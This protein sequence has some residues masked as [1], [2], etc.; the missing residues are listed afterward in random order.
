MVDIIGDWWFV[1]VNGGARYYC[2]TE[3]AEGVG[4]AVVEVSQGRHERCGQGIHPPS[5]LAVIVCLGFA[6]G[7]A[8]GTHR[9]TKAERRH[10]TRDVALAH[11]VAPLFNARLFGT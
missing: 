9:P 4:L 3:D 2:S 8:L 6:E 11:V 7:V 10:I 5:L 1:R